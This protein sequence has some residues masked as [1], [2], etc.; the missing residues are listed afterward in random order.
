[1]Q[2][3]RPRNHPPSFARRPFVNS[4]T[5]NAFGGLDTLVDI[6]L[7]AYEFG[8]VANGLGSVLLSPFEHMLWMCM[9]A[10][11]RSNHFSRVSNHVPSPLLSNPN[12]VSGRGS[13]P[14]GRSCSN[15]PGQADM[16]LLELRRVPP[17]L[18]QMDHTLLA[19]LTDPVR[20]GY[21]YLQVSPRGKG[22]LGGLVLTSDFLWLTFGW[23]AIRDNRLPAIMSVA[24]IPDALCITP[25]NYTEKWLHLVVRQGV[26]SCNPSRGNPS[27]YKRKASART[28]RLVELV[29]LTENLLQK[30]C[31]R[32]GSS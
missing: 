14:P 18:F 1:M 30:L 26:Q 7:L 31:G 28:P 17:S 20:P 13:V 21:N 8:M 16:S 12:R 22:N 5:V 2:A 4:R 10:L 24:P 15:S 23:A 27:A 25:S 6:H 9:C 11:G 29:V 19:N 32:H 3:P